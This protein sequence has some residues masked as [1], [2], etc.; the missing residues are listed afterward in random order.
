[1]PLRLDNVDDTVDILLADLLRGSFDHD[2]DDRLGTALTDQDT[3][4]GAE[5]FADFGDRGLDVGVVLG[6]G[7]ALDADVLQDLRVELDRAAS[8]L[9]G[10][11]LASMTSIILREVRMPSPVVAY[12][13]KM[14]WP[15]CSPP[16]RWPFSTM[17]S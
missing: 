7:F 10:F 14:I 11:S 9:I 17:F 3:A 13:V 2:A 8:S 6:V 5:L 16:T 4:G 1:M 12:F 15:D